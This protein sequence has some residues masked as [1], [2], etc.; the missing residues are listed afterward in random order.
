ATHIHDPALIKFKGKYYLFATHNNISIST[1]P[2]LKGPWARIGEV[3][4]GGSII[5]NTGSVDPWAPD[6]HEVGGTFYLYYAVS[7]FG[8]RKS[9][10][11][12]ATSKSLAPGTWTDHGA[13]VT[14]GVTTNNPALRDT[15]AIDPNLFY[16]PT[17]RTATLQLGSFWSDIWQIPMET[18]LMSAAKTGVHLALDPVSPSPVEAAFLHRAA[19]GW[20]YL[21]VSHGIC[22]GY[23]TP[24]LPSPGKEY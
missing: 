22:C 6:V 7:T 3:L 19:N 16:D 13:V 14:S 5:S 12:V 2:S 23:G 21:Y 24:P 9:S 17:T 1:A 4:K 10:I 11:G 18:N 15:N 20:Y 8:T